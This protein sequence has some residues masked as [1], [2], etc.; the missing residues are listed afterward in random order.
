MTPKLRANA[1]KVQHGVGEM[2]K[3]AEEAISGQRIV[4]IFGAQDYENERFS[5]VV[6]KNR[7]L[8]LRSARISGLNSLVVELLAAVRFGFGGLLRIGQFHVGRVRRFC[9]RFAN[10]D[11]SH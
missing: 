2:T 4:K 3:A 7:Q 6:S 1:K 8:E 11:F 9:R 5:V 10:A